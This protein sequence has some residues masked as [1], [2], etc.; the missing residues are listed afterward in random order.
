VIRALLL[1]PDVSGMVV[2]QFHDE[3]AFVFRQ[4]RGDLLDELLLT[5][6]VDG[7]E[8][9]VFMDGLKQVLIFGLA[10]LLGVREGRDM[11]EVSLVLQL[12]R[13]ACCQIEK[14]L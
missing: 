5:L 13:T 14:F 4:R 9:L 2:G 10:L 12:A 1:E 7:R 3:R 8:H 6:N 11:T